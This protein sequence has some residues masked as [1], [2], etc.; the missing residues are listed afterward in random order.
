[1]QLWPNPHFL[2]GSAEL[3]GHYQALKTSRRTTSAKLKFQLSK[4]MKFVYLNDFFKQVNFFLIQS[5]IEKTCGK[6]FQKSEKKISKTS[7][8]KS[9]PQSKFKAKINYNLAVNHRYPQ[10]TKVLMIYLI[11]VR[12]SNL[13]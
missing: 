13:E 8:A 5:S 11:S 9:I 2:A 4:D 1:M 7:H 6:D 3:K 10:K 12:D